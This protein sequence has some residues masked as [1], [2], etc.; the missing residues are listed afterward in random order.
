VR[1]VFRLLE[2]AVVSVRT[3]RFDSPPTGRLGG[4]DARPGAF[5]R[6]TADGRRVP[7]PS[8]A[9][10]VRFDAGDA[11]VV[12]TSGGGGLGDP[13][14]RSEAEVRRDVAIGVVSPE[15]AASIYGVTITSGG[16]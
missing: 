12:E 14:E 10:N 11:F 9:V 4:H 2:D 15:A 16:T 8:K 6:A 1:T 3:D 7:I 13:R 5:L